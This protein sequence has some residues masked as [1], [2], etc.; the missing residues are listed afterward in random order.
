MTQWF[1]NDDA[2]YLAWLAAHDEGYV[3]NTYA[4][5]AAGYLV[6][7]RASCRMI[8]RDLAA[9]K[10]WTGQYAKACADTVD[11]LLAWASERTSG[12]PHG[13]GSCRPDMPEAPASTGAPA[14]RSGGSRAINQA[15]PDLML[16]GDPII[17]TIR[18]VDD[19]PPI[20]IHGAQWVADL[21][22]RLDRSAVGPKSYD[23]RAL[24]CPK[25]RLELADLRAVN[26]SMATRMPEKW[27]IG[28]LDGVPRPWLTAID[29]SWRLLD[30]SDAEWKE[31]QVA[32]RLGAALA[33]MV[34]D[35]RGLSVA[36][37]LLHLK[38]PALVPIL[39]S[40]VVDQLG[41]RGRK[42]TKLIEHMRVEGRQNLDALRAMQDGLATIIGVDGQPIQRTLVRI[43]DVLLWATHPA[44]ALYP[45]LGHWQSEFQ[46][47]GPGRQAT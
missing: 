42:A 7:H 21:F 17:V 11:E 40:L 36:T 9:G 26:G 46:Y 29:P 14:R 16:G 24:A 10:V 13:C 1:L 6:V 30:L 18:R 8:N 22:F 5:L 37:K 12:T 47:A 2:G 38:R 19:G 15:A 34:G 43:L 45:V 35:H 32:D 23:A 3:L 4:H 20:V 31:A 39:D 33:E 25:D 27:W 41:G 28:L 44:S